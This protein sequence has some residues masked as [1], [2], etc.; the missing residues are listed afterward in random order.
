MTR[1]IG[2]ALL[3]SGT[4]L[5]YGGIAGGRRRE[6]CALRELIAALEFLERGVRASLTP[7]PRLLA[8]RGLGVQADAF[9]TRLRGLLRADDGCSF[10]ECWRAAAEPLPLRPQEK[11]MLAALGAALGGEEESVLLA[12]QN[13]A[14]ALRTALS[15]REAAQRQESRL[16]GTLCFSGGLLLTILLL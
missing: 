2:A 6:L 16:S 8:Q 7:M 14:R 13:T 11:E 3:L 10:A 5:L 15:A 9:F 4:A 12:L 1:L